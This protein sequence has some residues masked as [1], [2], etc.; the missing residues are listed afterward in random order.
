MEEPFALLEKES[1]EYFEGRC[2]P[3]PFELE[4]K[5]TMVKEMVSSCKKG[6]WYRVKWDFCELADGSV[7]RLD[8]A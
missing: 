1:Y 7:L 8:A 5:W 6:L 3:F 4:Y 2:V